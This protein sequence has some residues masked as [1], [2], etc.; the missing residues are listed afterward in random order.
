MSV[1]KTLVRLLHAQ[2]RNAD[3]RR[4]FRV[5]AI[6]NIAS[7][8]EEALHIDDW[9]PEHKPV[10]LIFIRDVACD[11]ERAQ[12]GNPECSAE[13][14]P[15]GARLVLSDEFFATTDTFRV[16]MD[17][18]FDVVVSAKPK[19]YPADLCE[20]FAKHVF[21]LLRSDGLLLLKWTEEAVAW[22]KPWLQPWFSGLPLSADEHSLD[23]GLWAGQRREPVPFRAAFPKR[24]DESI[25]WSCTKESW[26][27]LSS[28]YLWPTSLLGAAVTKE[29]SRVHVMPLDAPGMALYVFLEAGR[30]M[31]AFAD[32]VTLATASC[33]RPLHG[34]LSLKLAHGLEALYRFQNR[35]GKLRFRFFQSG[36]PVGSRRPASEAGSAVSSNRAQK[37]FQDL[38]LMLAYA[39]APLLHFHDVVA[40]DVQS[41]AE[42]QKLSSIRSGGGGGS[43]QALQV[44]VPEMLRIANELRG[45]ANEAGEYELTEVVYRRA[46]DGQ[47]IDYGILKAVTSQV[48]ERGDTVADL[49]ASLGGYS[50]FLNRTGM[51]EAF[52]FDGAANINSVTGGKVRNLQLHHPFTLWQRFDWILCL[53]VLEHIPPQ[54]ERLA[55][56][57]IREHARKG[58]I[59]S[60]AKEYTNYMDPLHVNAK[61]DPAVKASLASVGFVRDEQLTAAVRGSSDLFWLQETVAVYRV[62]PD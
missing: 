30:L 28:T 18:S 53:E 29:L 33:P 10:Q 14:S 47:Q 6:G 22:A 23:L 31:Q 3:G 15:K 5:L 56:R 44:Q 12:L 39:K 27:N 37:I 32:A 62:S 21:N 17:E 58:A 52:A 1:L 4:H 20:A 16:R 41:P 35:H 38:Q 19:G 13:L 42:V 45:P 34:P 24:P 25:R 51:F 55:L 46:F 40:P 49:G 60:W 57:N 11:S 36:A 54:S 61:D 7:P 2:Q 26:R 50:I 8:G 43:E 48:L 59:I 9:L